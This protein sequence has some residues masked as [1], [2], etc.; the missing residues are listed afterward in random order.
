[1]GLNEYDG[2]VT[3]DELADGVWLIRK[4]SPSVV[5]G[6]DGESRCAKCKHPFDPTDPSF[7][8]RAQHRD[9]PFCRSCVDHCQSTEIADHWCAVDQ[10]HGD[11]H[12]TDKGATDDDN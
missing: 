8:G 10:W 7:D 2:P 1:M 3:V 9:T 5:A 12:R 4:A 6:A 11:A